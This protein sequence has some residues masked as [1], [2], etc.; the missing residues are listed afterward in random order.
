MAME[1][2]WLSITEYSEY[3]GTSI[4]TVRRYIKASRVKHKFE[5]GKH[6]VF[7]NEE[8]RERQNLKKEAETLTLQ[9]KIKELEHINKIIKEENDDLKMLVTIYEKE[10]LPPIIEAVSDQI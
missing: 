9:M 3:R 10:N 6:W 2:I 4:S 1:G 5:N 7:V 8:N